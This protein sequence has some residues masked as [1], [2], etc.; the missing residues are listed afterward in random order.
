MANEN[1]VRQHLETALDGLPS[2]KMALVADF[3]K[4]LKS[5]E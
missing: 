5:R 4:Y 1:T 2:P 3:A